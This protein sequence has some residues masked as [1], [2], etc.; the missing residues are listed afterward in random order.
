MSFCRWKK[1]RYSLQTPHSRKTC[2]YRFLFG[3]RASLCTFRKGSLTLETALALPFFLC[4]VAALICLF[5]VSASQAVNERS[6]MEKAQ[7][8]A[9][10]AG[11]SS[12]SDPYIVLYGGASA[13]L[14]FPELFQSRG[15]AVCKAAV[16]SWVGYTGETFTDQKQEEMVYITPEGTVYHRERDCTYLRLT[17]H[18]IVPGDLEK[19]RNLS[20][21]KYMPCEACMQN[22]P[23]YGP[24]YITDYGSSYHSTREC[25]GLKR[26]VMAVPLS[27]TGGY[28]CCFRCGS[29]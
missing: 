29:R 11:Q 19:V 24:L 7:A 27:E 16:R 4:A 13:E 22:R 20:G 8:L 14:P 26:T 12:E 23:V 21:G 5:S 3:R 10:T 2:F 28:R 25:R 15:R 9:V 17:I 6:L 18:T 1:Y